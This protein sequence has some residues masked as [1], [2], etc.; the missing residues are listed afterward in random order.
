MCPTAQR[1]LLLTSTFPYLELYLATRLVPLRALPTISTSA[2][3]A[4]G[5]RH[6]VPTAFENHKLEW[7]VVIRATVNVNNGEAQR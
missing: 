4:V 7:Y 3:L 2:C 6:A 1:P 5:A